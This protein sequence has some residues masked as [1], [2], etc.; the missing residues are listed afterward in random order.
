MTECYKVTTLIVA[1]AQHP[2]E[3]GIYPGNDFR[4]RLDMAA[5]TFRQPAEHSSQTLLYVPGSLHRGDSV[6]LSE[7]GVDYLRDQGIP[8]DVLRGAEWNTLFRNEKG[9]YCTAD[10]VEVA[11]RGLT[12]IAKS[13]ETGRRVVA[14]CALGQAARL[15]L[16]YDGFGLASNELTFHTAG[17]DALH[18]GLTERFLTHYTIFDP[19]WRGPL[20]E[21]IR[22]L[23]RPSSHLPKRTPMVA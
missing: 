10:E 17:S 14:V 8:R 11:V 2:I 7:A 22:S 4:A 1:H 6:S 21:T 9:V 23:R 15:K 12:E 3:N 20:P 18:E 13:K 16:H 19:R 5:L